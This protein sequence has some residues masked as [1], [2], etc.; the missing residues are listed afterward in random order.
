[1]SICRK[2]TGS[3]LG[4]LCCLAV[5]LH[6][7][8][9]S[10]GT[11][12]P[13][14]LNERLELMRAALGV[15][16]VAAAVVHG[17]KIVAIGAAGLRKA[18]SAQP[19]TLSDKWH[20]GSCTKSMTA[21]LAGTLV[22]EGRMR[23]EMTVEEMFPHLSPE[24]QPEWRGATLEQFLA[25]HGGAPTDLN[26]D[27]LWR[28]LWSRAGDRPK[29]Q[30]AYLTRELLT[31]QKPAAPPGSTAIYS[32]A[33]YALVGHAIELAAGCSF[34]DLLRERVFEPLRL[35]SAGFGA[36]AN[37]DR[38]N[39]PWGHLASLEGG[40]T[41][42]TPGLTADNPAVLAPAGTVHASI[43]DL[44]NY[45]SWHLTGRSDSK[46]PLK[47]GTLSRLH[48]QYAASAH[49]LGWVASQTDGKALVHHGSNTMFYTV[50]WL[51]PEKSFGVVVCTN[52]GGSRGQ[53]A[54]DTVK[55]ALIEHHLRG[56]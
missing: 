4:R 3:L 28:R 7:D 26:E 20:I 36:P 18:S 12:A 29:D 32:N 31:K 47:P 46:P 56:W 5:S 17:D 49:A 37:I 8:N 42:A 55:N 14:S 6:A 51:A 41:P 27:G 2:F 9:A 35:R 21:A 39:Q 10:I 48:V 54:V 23:W 24:L 13:V 19:V 1:M 44:A 16:A 38:S 30:R 15:P 53:K 11:P 45:L 34:E 22:D 33:G 43:E 50:M 40:W 52:A 25:H